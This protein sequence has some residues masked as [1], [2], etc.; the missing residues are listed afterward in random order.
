MSDFKFSNYQNEDNSGGPDLVGITSFTTPFYF[1]PPSGTTAQRPSGDGLAPGTLRFNTD[2]GRL[3]VWRGDY[4][5]TIL[6][7][8]SAPIGPRGVFGRGNIIDYVTIATTG[9]AIYFGNLLVSRS[10][11]GACASSTRGLFASGFDGTRSNVIEYVTISSTGNA[12]DFGDLTSGRSGA[13]SLSSSTRGIWAGGF[14]TTNIIDYVTI[15]STGNAQDFGDLT[16]ARYGLAACSSPTRGLFNG[17][18]TPSQQNVIDYITIASTG[19]A[20]DFGDL[21]TGR[22]YPA[23]CASSIRAL[24]SGGVSVSAIEYLTISTSGNATKFG[25]LSAVTFGHAGCSSPIRGL[26]AGGQVGPSPSPATN[27]IE[28]VTIQ[29]LSN[30]TDFG[31]LTRT[32]TSYF[33]ACSNAHGGL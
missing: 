22:Y 24:V 32:A 1:V 4:W 28:F 9:N 8:E 18:N 5:A 30:S 23:M 7:Q 31:D 3:E 16:F 11:I 15:S 29:T 12:A 26:F 2:I 19:N 21:F 20:V 25:D 17:S 33:S 6:G 13:S 27:T 10:E 14:P